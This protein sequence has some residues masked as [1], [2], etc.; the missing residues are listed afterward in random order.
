[1]TT[2]GKI[3]DT[4]R[5]FKIRIVSHPAFNATRGNPGQ[6]LTTTDIR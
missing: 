2:G 5:Y 3:R 6:N 1:M 4:P